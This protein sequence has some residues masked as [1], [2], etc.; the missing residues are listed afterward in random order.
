VRRKS[1]LA[2]ALDAN[3][4]ARHLGFVEG[5]RATPS[6]ELVL[7]LA[8]ALDVP[9][10]ERN[11][12]LVAAGYAPIY[13]ETGLA[14][15]EMARARTA[16]ECILRQQEPHPAVVMDRHWN[17]VMTNAAAAAFFGSL[18]KPSIPGP[19]N[20]IRLMFHPEALRPFVQN[21]E[22][23]AEALVQRLHREAVGGVPDD[24]TTRLLEE[25]LGYPGVPREW[26]RLRPDASALPFLPIEF[27]VGDRV[28]KYFSTV[29]TLGTPLDI[30]LQEIRI[31]CFHPSD[32]ATEQYGRSTAVTGIAGRE[33]MA[34]S[35]RR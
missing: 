23:V 33:S 19:A 10:R 30:T 2:L 11:E 34:P 27:R 12:L 3:V 6:R 4:S 5:G 20:I 28:L 7:V 22:L 14:A 31:E 35:G 17:I 24:E 13:R 8:D 18:P 15:P 26:G 1:Q 29:T 16:L 25:V 32:D 9:L 21:W